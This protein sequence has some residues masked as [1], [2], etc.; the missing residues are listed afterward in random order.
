M[1][2]PPPKKSHKY[3]QKISGFFGKFGTGANA[4]IYFVQAGLKPIDLHKTTLIGDIPGSECWPVRDLFQRDVDKYR[5]TN[6]II[7]YFKDTDKVKFFN[8]LTLTLLPV[9]PESNAILT[10]IPVLKVNEFEEDNVLWISYEAKGCYRFKHVKDSAEYG[11][12]E[13]NDSLV[14]IVAIDGQ[15]RLSALKRYYNDT[16]S[17]KGHNDF[18]QWTIPAVI[19]GLDRIS[20]KRTH[21]TDILHAIRNVFIYINTTAQ[22]PN[23]ARQILLSDE[24]INKICTQELLD[25]AH[26]NDIN[27]S[28][29]RIRERVPLLFFD[30][31]GEQKGK[32]RLH[33]PTAMKKSEEIH[34]WLEH[35]ILGDDFETKQETALG[36]QPI[37]NLHEAFS[38]KK[39]T[40]Q[41]A[42]EVRKIFSEYL[43]P[44]L[45]YFLENFTPYK[46]YI[47]WLRVLEDGY[48][49]KSDIA[50]HAFYRLRFGNDRASEDIRQEVDDIFRDIVDEI[51][52]TKHSIPPLIQLDIGLRGLMF[53]F[54]E[55]REYYAQTIEDT[56]E[57]LDYSKWFTEAT[58]SVYKNNWFDGEQVIKKWDLQKHITHDQVD[59]VVNYRF[60]AAENALGA[61]VCLLVGTYGNRGKSIPDEDVLEKIYTDNFER[62]SGTLLRG[63][64]KEVRPKLREEYPQGGKPLNK[65]VAKKAQKMTD[66]H[67][68]KLEKALRAI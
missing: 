43:L 44:G 30:W 10:T 9:D 49:S 29:S 21:G 34:D 2:G 53:A 23:R 60:E 17:S 1:P 54:S 14:K 4:Q 55:M 7:P 32:E 28:G 18:L 31:R 63:Y 12:I 38:G 64:K 57:W 37:N 27:D 67:L 22:E 51:V 25:Y 16:E 59:V 5:V 20:N 33:S 24:S 15:H 3:N 61:L 41:S 52:D 58:N 45:A 36:I 62:L 35:Y 47:E 13:W 68:G 46:E 48:T 56:A 40:P 6:S 66:K 8:P 50:R 65:A 42:N 39:L 11:S 26:S 19:F